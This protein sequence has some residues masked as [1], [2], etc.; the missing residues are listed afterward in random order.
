MGFASIEQLALNSVADAVLII[1]ENTFYFAN[2]S[3]KRLTGYDES[4]SHGKLLPL[5][6]YTEKSQKLFVEYVSKALTERR[7]LLKDFQVIHQGTSRITST[8]VVFTPADS[9]KLC[10]TF[11]PAFSCWDLASILT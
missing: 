11:Q 9:S 5:F 6:I 3:F 2:D 10:C 8:N 7:T 1:V 4:I